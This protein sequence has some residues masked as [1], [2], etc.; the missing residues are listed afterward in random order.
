MK[1]LP[2]QSGSPMTNPPVWYPT[3]AV[4]VL[5]DR[6]N[7]TIP[8]WCNENWSICCIY[9]F[10]SFFMVT[11]LV[12]TLI[13]RES[14]GRFQH[15]I[16][17]FGG[18]FDSCPNGLN[19]WNIVDAEGSLE[20]RWITKEKTYRLCKGCKWFYTHYAKVIPSDSLRHPRRMWK[21]VNK[22]LWQGGSPCFTIQKGG[23]L[24]QPGWSARGPSPLLG[25]NRLEQPWKTRAV[26]GRNSLVERIAFPVEKSIGISCP[27]IFAVG[28]D[29]WLEVRMPPILGQTQILLATPHFAFVP[30]VVGKITSHKKM[31]MPTMQ[32]FIIITLAMSCLKN[33]PLID[34]FP[35]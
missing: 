7:T 20:F 11:K 9:V 23:F 28:H 3:L 4:M 21:Y 33:P 25:R 29:I 8:R 27:F 19:Q 12:C 13:D 30:F 18:C 35:I 34:D 15:Y 5:W 26:H 22:G 10:S 6:S 31:S 16:I 17:Y 24:D 2:W 14:L 32:W 1:T